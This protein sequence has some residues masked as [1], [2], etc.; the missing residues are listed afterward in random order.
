MGSS[1]WVLKLGLLALWTAWFALVVATNVCDVLKSL[2]VLPREWRFASQNFARVRDAVAVY[3]LP[4]GMAAVLF[5]AVVLWQALTALLLAK[6]LM[7]SIGAQTLA[8][9][10]VDLAFASALGLWAGFILAEEIFK[11]YKTES[12]HLLF[13][14][15]QLLTLTA[16]HVLP[17]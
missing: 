15:A 4:R 1:L 10:Q 8:A 13:F 9:E 3:G 11:Q 2:G 14:I 7:A 5:G 12:K 16:L 17:G 6:A